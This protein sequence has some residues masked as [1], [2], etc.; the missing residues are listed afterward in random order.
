M[1]SKKRITVEIVLNA[2]LLMTIIKGLIN[3]YV[4]LDLELSKY[5]EL[6]FSNITYA[7]LLCPILLMVVVIIYIMALF[8]ELISDH[9]SARFINALRLI[10]G[11]SEITIMLIHFCIVVPYAGE[12]SFANNSL[13]MFLAIPLMTFI[14]FIPTR[15]EYS[16]FGL[17]Y[18]NI[19]IIL[20]FGA[21]I[22]L[23]SM[24]IINAPYKF[25]D[26][27]SQEYYKIIINIVIILAAS[28]LTT[29]LLMLITRPRGKRN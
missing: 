24:H 11:V 5:W 25:I 23:Y 22:A 9:E 12:F 6:V 26:I 18:G 19:G 1:M 16:S 21:I 13:Y 3:S 8:H 14:T 20:Y 4:A 2:L 17:L 29:G 7:E 10:V 28:S 27:Y 15:R